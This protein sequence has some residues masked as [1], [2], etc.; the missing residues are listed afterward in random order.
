MLLAP[1]LTVVELAYASSSSSR[2]RFLVAAEACRLAETH[3]LRLLPLA[4]TC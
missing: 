1:Y 4:K 2:A 3:S